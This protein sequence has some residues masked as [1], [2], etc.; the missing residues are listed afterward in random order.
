MKRGGVRRVSVPADLGFG[1]AGAT[2]P[3]GTIVPP[4]AAL[5]IVVSVEDVTPN[6]F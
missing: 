2:L 1:A 4:N 5:D 6:Y 3:D